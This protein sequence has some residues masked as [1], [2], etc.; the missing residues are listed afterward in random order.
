MNILVTRQ[1]LINNLHVKLLTQYY[2]F[3]ILFTKCIITSLTEKDV[4][5]LPVLGINHS[6]F[7]VPLVIVTKAVPFFLSVAVARGVL[8]QR[9]FLPQSD[10]T[11]KTVI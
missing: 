4:G 7:L 10:N 9:V 1:I 11:N 3:I 5:V 6:I 8:L 2:T